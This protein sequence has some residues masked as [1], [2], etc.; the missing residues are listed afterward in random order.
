MIINE[1]I[2]EKFKNNKIALQFMLFNKICILLELIEPF[3]LNKISYDE[4]DE[5]NSQDFLKNDA[6]EEAYRM[7]I[8]NYLIALLGNKKNDK[9]SIRKISNDIEKNRFD[10]F[11]AENQNDYDNLYRVRDTVYAHFDFQHKDLNDISYKFIAK[12]IIY[13]Q[14]YFDRQ[15]EIQFS[16]SMQG[17]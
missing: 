5:Q 15:P 6:I 4:I 3:L 9:C 17:R 10:K 14:E 11:I 16:N 12:C 8:V 13:L 7:L 1:E 2:L